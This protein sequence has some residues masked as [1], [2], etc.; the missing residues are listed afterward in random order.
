MA[1]PG[2]QDPKRELYLARGYSR[3][4]GCASEEL[5]SA[6]RRRE[7][8]REGIDPDLRES[9][10]EITP[11]SRKVSVL[12]TIQARLCAR[13]TGRPLC[14]QLGHEQRQREMQVQAGTKGAPF[15]FQRHDREARARKRKTTPR[16]GTLTLDNPPLRCP[17]T[18]P[19]PNRC[20]ELR[21]NPLPISRPRVSCFW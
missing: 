5:V 13:A 2:V 14:K 6:E 20:T 11:V 16:G 15:S 17:P 9:F 4:G 1:T 7:R 12:A 19:T 10:S 21:Q 3:C 8:E 18:L